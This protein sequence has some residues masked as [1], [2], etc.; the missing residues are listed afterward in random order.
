MR[1]EYTLNNTNKTKNITKTPTATAKSILFFGRGAYH[2]IYI[3]EGATAIPK[4]GTY[5]TII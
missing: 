4:Y 2:Y 1:D 5:I 3:K